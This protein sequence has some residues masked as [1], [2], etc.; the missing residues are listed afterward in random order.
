MCMQ[1]VPAG[2]PANFAAKVLA[3]TP[4]IEATLINRHAKSRGCSWN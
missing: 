4:D 2:F 3:E 1:A